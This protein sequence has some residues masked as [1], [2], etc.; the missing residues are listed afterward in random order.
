MKLFDKV[1][2]T[3]SERVLKKLDGTIKKIDELGE[4]YKDY[5]DDQLRAMTPA[6]KERLAAGQSLDDILPEAF[7]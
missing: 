6:L 2:G 4:V 1:F 7:A 5:T 3:Y